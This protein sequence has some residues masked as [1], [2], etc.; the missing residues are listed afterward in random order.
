MLK[1]VIIECRIDCPYYDNHYP[2][3]EKLYM[4]LNRETDEM[5]I[6]KECPLEDAEDL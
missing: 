1:N 6:D 5:S 2:W 4:K 3:Y